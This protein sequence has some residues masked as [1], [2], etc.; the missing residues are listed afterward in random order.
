M[1]TTRKNGRYGWGSGNPG[2]SAQEVI[3]VPANCINAPPS[4]DF[5]HP[6]THVPKIDEINVAGPGADLAQVPTKDCGVPAADVVNIGTEFVP[7]FPI[8]TICQGILVAKECTL[9]GNIAQMA[10][11]A[12]GLRCNLGIGWHDDAKIEDYRRVSKIY[13]Y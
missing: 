9:G 8:N 10:E 11:Q 5:P 7:F 3:G 2:V 6:E 13:R 4:V 1:T 12:L